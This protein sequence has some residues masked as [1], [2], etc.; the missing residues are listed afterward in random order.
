MDPAR[1]ISKA[2]GTVVKTPGPHGFYAFHPKPIPRTI[3]F[4]PPT[5][6]A[7][8]DAEAALGRLAGAGRLLPNPHILI[9][10]Y[11]TREAL[12]SSSIEGTQASF[13]EVFEADA[14]KEAPTVDVREVQN[15][16]AAM[17]HGLE[18][19]ESLPLS[20]RLLREIHTRLMTGVRGGDRTP[21]EFRASP[22]WIGSPDDRPDTAIFVP[23]PPDV[24]QDALT[25]LERFM[26]DDVQVP[27]LVQCALLHYQFET[28]HAFLDGNGRVGR[29]LAVF[30]LVEKNRL[31][32]PLLY[33]SGHF[34]QHRDQYYRRLQAVRERGELQEWIQFFLQAVAT[35][36]EDAVDRAERLADLRE[37]YRSELAITTRSRA[38]EVVDLMVAQP[39]I[40][41]TLVQD[42][43][44]IT[45]QGAL[46]LIRRIESK[47]WLHRAGTFGRGGRQL[48]VAPE[49]LQ[50][51]EA[52]TVADL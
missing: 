50:V 52:A 22:N 13:S 25:D 16:V 38:L 17:R 45:H 39:V 26:H 15:Y 9:G 27:L 20:L 1:Y 5:V 12:A 2:Y 35:Q 32:Q 31:P 24:M 47:G 21:G 30:F 43:L 8:A 36:A 3:A 40:T 18:L 51:I 33:L 7:L 19:I 11:M 6:M 29:L 41:A 44:N 23:P 34:E 10:P 4:D 37:R 14:G 49:I 48:W 28:I 42:R 46:N